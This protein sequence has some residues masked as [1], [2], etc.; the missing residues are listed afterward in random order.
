MNGGWFWWGGKD[1]A[2]FIKLWRHMFEYFTKTK[3]LDN[4]LW[5]YGPNHGS[6]NDVDPPGFAGI[7]GRDLGGDAASREPRTLHL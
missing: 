5:V 3:D 4:L 1:P 7:T 2:V 6:K